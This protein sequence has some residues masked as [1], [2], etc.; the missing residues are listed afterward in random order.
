MSTPPGDAVGYVVRAEDGTMEAIAAVYTSV[1]G[2]WWAAFKAFGNCPLCV[3]KYAVK[4][5]DGLAKGGVD[6]VFAEVDRDIDRAEAW[7]T[8]LGFV[9]YSGD[10]WRLSLG[11]G[12]TS[13][14]SRIGRNVDLVGDKAEQSGETKP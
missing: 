14:G 11:M 3:H 7:M 2:D 8:R 6:Y 1:T 9:P 12:S 5:R 10:V 13:S 4:L